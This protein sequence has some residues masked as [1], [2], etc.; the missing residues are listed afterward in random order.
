MNFSEWKSKVMGIL[1]KLSA[2]APT[3]EERYELEELMQRLKDLRQR[4]LSSW[5]YRLYIYCR[6]YNRMNLCK[7]VTE[8]LGEPVKMKTEHA[9]HKG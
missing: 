3:K 5:L 2:E 1:I 7:E 9:E 4:D 6:N 8:S